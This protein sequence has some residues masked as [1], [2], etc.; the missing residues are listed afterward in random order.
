MS[1]NNEL[2]LKA[3]RP[4]LSG[5]TAEPPMAREHKQAFESYVRKG[6]AQGLTGLEAK[7]FG[8]GEHGV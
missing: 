8:G 2:T 1:P 4:Q 5:E 7:A 3:R 6:E